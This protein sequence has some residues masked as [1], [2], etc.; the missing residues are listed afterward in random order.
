MA[1]IPEAAAA[2]R[3]DAEAGHAEEGAVRDYGERLIEPTARRVRLREIFTTW[4]VTKVLVLRELQSRYKQSALGPI[5]LAVQPLAMA[6][7]FT[8]VFSGVADVSTGGVPY[9]LFSLIGITVWLAIQMSVIYG[10][11]T[12]AANKVL[13]QS[14]PVPRLALILSSILTVLP[15]FVFTLVL[16]FICVLALGLGLRVEMLAVPALTV[17]LFL[18][19]LFLILPLASWHARYRDVGSTVPFLFQAALFLSPVAY[20][21][22][23]AGGTL[24]TLLA[25][26]PVTG[27]I[28]AWRWCLL[29]STPDA[30]S[31]LL[32]GGW[33]LVIGVFGWRTFV[34]AEVRFA[35]VV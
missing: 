26:N 30:L 24:Q 11:R 4:P 22:S 5:W 23:E 8:V 3:T 17:W 33:T 14:V 32:A 27:L 20:P 19:L 16:S 15:Q 25:F 2:T 34:K 12:I 6:G 35:D 1:A 9:V 21:L 28:E 10:T 13:V 7:G 31:L 29:G 18:F